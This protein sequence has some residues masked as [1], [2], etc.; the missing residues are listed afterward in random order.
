MGRPE[1]TIENWWNINSAIY[2]KTSFM[3][4]EDV[5]YGK[6]TPTESKLNLLGDLRG[7]GVLDLGCGGGQNSVAL[8]KRGAL[9]T[10]LDISVEQLKYARRLAKANGVH[11][12][13]VRKS[14][15]DLRDIRRDTYD[16]AF[17]AFALQY[18]P[19]L[20]NFFKEVS[21][22]VRPGGGFVFS[23][24]H[25]FF[26]TIDRRT[27]CVKLPYSRRKVTTTSD[28]TG[29]KPAKL[30]VFRYT[31]SDYCNGLVEAGFR[32]EKVV[33]DKDLEHFDWLF[34]NQVWMRN[35]GEQFPVDLLKLLPTAI[36]FKASKTP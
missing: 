6:F 7:K 33:E 27:G 20:K 18:V 13:F 30:V 29:R 34:K 9:V 19:N 16:L 2:Q 14:F 23:T 35:W 28:W 31:V 36:V 1:K 21:R 10:A 17:S 3:G 11:V 25:P 8:A 12:D 22:V 32:V 24:H 15:L 26:L 5:E 4:T